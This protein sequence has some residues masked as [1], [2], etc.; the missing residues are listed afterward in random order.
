MHALKSLGHSRAGL[1]KTHRCKIVVIALGEQILVPSE[2]PEETEVFSTEQGVV[3]IV[4]KESV[5]EV[6]RLKVTGT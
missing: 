1:R 2:E 4:D 5:A 3:G 6:T